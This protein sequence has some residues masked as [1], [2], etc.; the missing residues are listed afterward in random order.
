M[1]TWGDFREQVREGFLSDAIDIAEGDT[2]DDYRWT[3]AQL[4]VFLHRGLEKFAEHTAVATATSFPGD[5]K[6]Y[7]L[8]SNLY[9][10][11]SLDVT[12]DVWLEGGNEK[13]YLD[14]IY[15]T[16]G[17]DRDSEG[18]FTRP[19]T[20]LHLTSEPKE[21]ETVNVNYYAHYDKPQ[22]DSDPITI[23][24]WGLTALTYII[25]F[26]AL[27]SPGLRSALIRQW[28]VKQDSGKPTDL[29]I[30]MQQKWVM[31]L[32]KEELQLYPRQHR[33][34]PNRATLR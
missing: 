7:D 10:A 25:T 8:P 30:T 13:R 29:P 5:G 33:T 31:S 11:E 20:V 14:P 15:A 26:F 23:P 18:F 6:Q 19:A 12:G 24:S 16:M 22:S 1:I 17:K 3:D 32:Y 9:Q 28:N 4:L 21:G 27:S 2:A 34:N